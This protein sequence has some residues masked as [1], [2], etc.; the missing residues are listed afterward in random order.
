MPNPSYSRP[1]LI[2]LLA[3]LRSPRRFLQVLA[4]PRQVG[5]S[6]L[7]R[8]AAA[9]LEVEGWAVVHASA[10]GPLL[11]AAGWIAAQWEIGRRRGREHGA[12]PVLLILDEIQKIPGWSEIVKREW[13]VDSAS[14]STMRVLLLGSSPL[15]VQR[16]LSE[17]LA[18]RFELLRASHWSYSEMHDAF[19][20][21]LD[22]FVFFGGYPGAAPLVGEPERWSRYVLDALIETA[23]S[24]D[25]LL[26]Q[27]V[28]KPALLRRLL[29]LVCAYSGQVLSYQ[30]M[31][32][33]LHDAGNTT[34]LAH[35]LDLLEGAGMAIGVSKYA[36]DVARQRSS[37]PK[38]LVLNTALLGA[39]S[40]ASLDEVRAD[41]QRS[42]R[43]V[44]SAI[45][46]HLAAAARRE[47]IELFYW[48]DRN[49][50]VDFVLR[51]GRRLVAIEVKSGR[52]R[53]ALPGLAAFCTAF[54]SA[55]PLLVGGDGIPLE[56]ALSTDPVSWLG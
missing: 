45:G 34:T 17:S 40:R 52:H 11:E 18:G 36:G 12:P 9:A 28:D 33:Q 39:T 27:R 16:G 13:D 46:A 22:R 24:R 30:K 35:Y 4:G 5:K 49:R 47:D 15:L 54:P 26:Q 37:S 25:V 21:D 7:A 31:L 42:G 43:F 41:G 6:T 38:L 1:I 55:R 50:E 20:F 51:R 53:D 44:E 32:G 3:R 14:G 10:D 23:V 56:D 29:D 2:D 19:G 48:R 8:Q